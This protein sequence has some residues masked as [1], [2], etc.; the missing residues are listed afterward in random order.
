MQLWVLHS[1]NVTRSHRENLHIQQH[2]DLW[3]FVGQFFDSVFTNW[4]YKRLLRWI[5]NRRPANFFSV[6]YWYKPNLYQQRRLDRVLLGSHFVSRNT[7]RTRCL[8]SPVLLDFLCVGLRSWSGLLVRSYENLYLYC[9]NLLAG[10]VNVD[11]HV[12]FVVLL[13]CCVYSLYFCLHSS[14]QH[15]HVQQQRTGRE[16]AEEI[17]RTKGKASLLIGGRERA[18]WGS[19]II[20]SYLTATLCDVWLLL[21]F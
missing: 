21:A 8:A 17:R 4:T 2:L 20:I 10:F 3:F 5:C 6:E 16:E 15:G 13:L 7:G 14:S 19:I 11:V 18:I 9:S 1:L 12:W